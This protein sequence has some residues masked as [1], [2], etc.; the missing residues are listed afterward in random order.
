MDDENVCTISQ[1]NK[2]TLIILFIAYKSNSPAMSRCN[3]N[4]EDSHDH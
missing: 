2:T 3:I 4:R 1:Q